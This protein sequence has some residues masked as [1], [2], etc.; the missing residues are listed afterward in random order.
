MSQC[1]FAHYDKDENGDLK[2][3]IYTCDDLRENIDKWKNDFESRMI[4]RD[5]FK[6]YQDR[7]IRDYNQSLDDALA[8]CKCREQNGSSVG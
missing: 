8:K 1:K 5:S 2:K 6:V 3:K 7:G 4:K